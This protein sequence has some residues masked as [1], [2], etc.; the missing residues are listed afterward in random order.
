MGEPPFE[1][2]AVKGT[3]A[4]PSPAVAVPMVGAPGAEELTVSER[5]ALVKAAWVAVLASVPFTVKV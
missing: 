3:D 1:A 4:L 2:G 5:V